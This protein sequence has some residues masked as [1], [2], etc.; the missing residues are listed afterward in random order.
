MITGWQYL[1]LSICGRPVTEIECK[2]DLAHTRRN[3]WQV[4][5][6]IAIGDDRL[7][8]RVERDGSVHNGDIISHTSLSH[9]IAEAAL[10]H[11]ANRRDDILEEC[12]LLADAA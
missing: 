4:N 1:T 12:G 5:A 9:A 8:I 3:G 7:S 2:F 11:F 10:F 6:V